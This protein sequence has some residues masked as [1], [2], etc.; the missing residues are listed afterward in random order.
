MPAILLALI[1]VLAAAIAVAVFLQAR[2]FA[3]LEPFPAEAYLEAP[4]NFQGNRYRVEGQVQ[5]Q[6]AFRPGT[7]RLVAVA[8]EDGFARIPL[9]LPETT[10]G[11]TNLTVGQ[12]YRFAVQVRQEGLLYVDDLAKF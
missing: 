4:A 9:F 5:D 1:L 12:R 7:G 10:S 2:P 8:V 6:I 11:T 3:G